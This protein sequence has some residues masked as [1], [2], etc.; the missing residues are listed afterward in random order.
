LTKNNSPN[1]NSLDIFYKKFEKDRNSP[2]GWRSIGKKLIEIEN[3]E[4]FSQNTNSLPKSKAEIV[5]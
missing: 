4:S 1:I 5:E 3:F 2:P